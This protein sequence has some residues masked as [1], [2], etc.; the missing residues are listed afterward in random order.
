LECAHITDTYDYVDRYGYKGI[1]WS[2]R[3]DNLVTLCHD[4]HSPYHRSKRGFSVSDEKFSKVREVNKLF[5]E[6]R[7]KREERN[8]EYWGKFGG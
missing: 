2:F 6:L 4:C 5:T 1:K 7:Q 3:W 8:P